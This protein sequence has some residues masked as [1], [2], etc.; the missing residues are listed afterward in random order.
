MEL[1]VCLEMKSYFDSTPVKVM[2]RRKCFFP[3]AFLCARIFLFT[4]INY[5]LGNSQASFNEFYIIV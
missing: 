1:L 3:H 2:H 5:Y 4:V